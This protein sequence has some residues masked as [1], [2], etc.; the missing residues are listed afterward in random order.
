MK[1]KIC[2]FFPLFLNLFVKAQDCIEMNDRASLI[3]IYSSNHN[4]TEDYY[5]KLQIVYYKEQ[6]IYNGSSDLRTRNILMNTGNPEI[7][8]LVKKAG[9]NRKREFIAFASIPLGIAA[10]AC[11]RSGQNSWIKPVGISLI[12]ASLSCIIISPIANH[13]KTANYRKAIKVYNTH[14]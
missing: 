3:N 11:I 1:I 2:L 12:T 4:S 7:L 5:H 9:K 8:H 13:R 14:F 10:A 6:S